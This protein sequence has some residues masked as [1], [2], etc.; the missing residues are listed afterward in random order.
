MERIKELREEKGLTQAQLGKELMLN[1][2]TISDYENGKLEPSVQTIIKLCDIFDI[3]A[4][5]LLG[6]KDF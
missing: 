4:D 1:Q 3:T 2:N 6:R 5:Y